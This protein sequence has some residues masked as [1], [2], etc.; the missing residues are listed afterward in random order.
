MPWLIYTATLNGVSITDSI[1]MTAISKDTLWSAIIPR[2]EAGSDIRY[3]IT[4]YDLVGSNATNTSGYSI[5]QPPKGGGT[6]EIIIGTG[7]STSYYSPYCADYNRSWTRA[8]YYDWEFNP[9]RTGALIASIAYDNNESR[10]STVDR[11]SMYVKATK[12]SVFTNRVYIDPVADGATLAWGEATYTT[13]Q[14]WNTFT[15]YTPF[16]LPPGYNLM[17]YWYDD[18]GSYDD[19]GMCT[20]NYT[21]QS[22]NNHIQ[23][24]DDEKLLPLIDARISIN[25]TRPNIKANM[26]QTDFPNNSVA[27]SSIKSPVQ[28]Q[29]VGGITTPVSV[30][31]HNKGD[32]NL[33]SATINWSVNNV[34]QTSVPWTGNLLWDFETQVTIGNYTP[35]TDMTDT[36]LIW[37]SSPNNKLDSVSSDD[38]LN[39]ITFGCVGAMAGTYTIGDGGMF[40]NINAFFTVLKD[41]IPSGDITLSLKT[42]TY[43]ENWDL[44]N[45]S[46]LMGNYTL[47]ITSF[48]ANADS[49]ILK[50]SSNVGIVL[51]N[52]NNLILKDITVDATAGT[53]AIQ[54]T[55]HCHNVMIRDCKLLAN[56][57]SYSTTTAPIYRRRYGPELVMD[58]VFIINNLLDGG[59]YGLYFRGQNDQ[60]DHIVFD[61]NTV[62]NQYYGIY[63]YGVDFISCSYNTI[64]C[65]TTN[66]SWYGIYLSYSHGN[67]IDNRI[68][69]HNSVAASSYGI[70]LDSYSSYDTQDTGLIANNEI[71]FH[72]TGSG[73]GIYVNYSRAKILYNSIYTISGSGISMPNAAYFCMIKNNNIIMESTDAFPIYLRTFGMDINIDYNNMYAPTYVGYAGGNKTTIQE[74]QQTVTTDHHSVSLYPGFIDTTINLELSN[75][76]GVRC[77]VLPDITRDIKGSFRVGS[78]SSMGCY[79]GVNYTLNAILETISGWRDGSVLGQTDTVKIQVTNTEKD[80]ITALIL[81]WAINGVQQTGITW[82]G[83]LPT[84]QN[85]I[86]PIGTIT[87][88]AGYYEI[89]AWISSVNGTQDEFSNDDT[90]SVIA[91]VCNTPLNGIYNIGATGDFPDIWEA[92]KILKLC[93]MDGDVVFAFQPGTYYTGN[94]DLT[95]NYKLFGNYQFTLTST[96][97]NA[98]DVVLKT[99][100]A[101]G[102][103]LSYSNNIVIKDL[104]IDA[105]TH[106][107]VEFIMPCTNIVIRDCRLLI[108]TTSTTSGVA[109]NRSVHPETQVE[110]I[111]S[112]FIINNFMDGGFY[113]I[114]LYGGYGLGRGQYGTNIV[115]D[116]NIISNSAFAGIWLQW[117]EFK[118]CSY[119][120]ILSRTVNIFS[121]WRGMYIGAGDGPVLSN[122]IIQRNTSSS[123]YYGIELD[124]YSVFTTDTGLV[125]NNEIILYANPTSTSQMC[126][127]IKI[128]S[129]LY[130]FSHAKILHNSIYIKG[131]SASR[132]IEI[133]DI[134]SSYLYLLTVMVKNNNIVMESPDAFPI[135]LNS[136]TNLQ[137]FD[138]DY[139]NMYA[140]TYVGYAGGNKATMAA[141]QQTITTDHNSVRVLPNIAN[142]DIS[143][144]PLQEFGLLCDTIPIVNQDIR[145]I[146][147]TGIAIMG[148]YEVLPATGNAMLETITGLREGYVLGQNDTI[149]VKVMNTGATA[150]TSVNFGW[151]V[152]GVI[153]SNNLSI[154]VSLSRWQSDTVSLGQLTYTAGKVVVKVWINSLNGGTLPDA[155]A[156]DDTLSSSVFVCNGGYSGTYIVGAT[157]DF[158]NMEE[159]C[160]AFNMCGVNG[161]IILAFQPGTYTDNIDLT[162]SA[163]IFGNYSL[164]LTSIT[165]IV[166]DVI[167]AP[168]AGVAINCNNTNNLTIKNITI[169]AT[170]GN[171]GI[172]FTGAASNITVDNCHILANPTATTTAYAAI[173]KS[174]SALNGFTVTNCTIDGGYYGIYLY[175]TSANSYQNIVIDNNIITNQYY[176]GMYLYYVNS[177]S[178]SYNHIIPRSTNAGTTWQ[179]LYG[180]YLRNGGNIVGNHISANTSAITSNLT[181]MYLYY[182][183]TAL[184]ANNEIYL[185]GNATTTDGIYVYYPRQVRVINNT[186]YT[187]KAGTSGTNRAHYNYIANGYSSEI[188]NNIFV[189]SGGAA[190]TTYAF[191]FYGS[192]A[193]FTNYKANYGV[194][195][196]DYYSTGTN[197]GYVAGA[198]RANLTVW[199][200]AI[201][202]LDAHSVNIFPDFANP[203][204]NLSLATYSDTLL[205]P[206]WQNVVT[207][208]RNL[209]RPDTTAMGAYI[210]FTEGKDLMLKG[211]SAWNNEVVNNQTIPVNVTLF[212][213]GT[214]PITTAT[215]GWSINNMPQTSVLWTAT[216]ALDLS[217]ERIVHLGSF[218][219]TNTSVHN[220]VVWIKDVNGQLDT[221]NWNDTI[222]ASASLKPLAEFVA[223]FLPDTIM[224]H[225]FNVNVLIRQGTGATIN[226]PKMTIISTVQGIG[227]SYD[228]VQLY[229]NGDI[230][231][232]TVPPQYLDAKVVYSVNISDSVGNTVTLT[233]SIYTRSLLSILGDTVLTGLSLSEPINQTGILCTPDFSSVSVMLENKGNMDYNFM[234]DSIAFELEITNPLQMKYTAHVPFLGKVSAGTSREVELINS[235]PIMYAGQY[236]IKVWI[237]RLVD[238]T[239]SEDTLHYTYTSSRYDLPIDDD[240]SNGIS[241]AFIPEGVNTSHTWKVINQG[242]GIDMAVQPV[243]G[244]SILSFTGSPGSMATLSTRQLDLSRTIQPSLSFWYFHDT[245]PCEDYTD[246]LITI[247]GG[248][249]YTTLLSV[250]KYDA[251]YGWKQ[252]SVDLPS[253]AINQCV[254]L[255][256]EAMEKSRSGNVTQY[257]DRILIIARQDIAISE[258]ITLELTACDLENR[259]VQVVLSNLTDPVLDFATTP[260]TITLE[261]NETGQTFSHSRTSGSLGSFASDTIPVATGVDFSPGTYTFKAYFSSVLDVDRMN[262]TL[263]ASIVINPALS[264]SVQPE[265][266]PANCLTGEL[267]VYPTITLYNMGNMDLSNIDMILQVDT[268]DNNTSVYTLLKE[269]YT[270]TILA[271]DTA[272]YMFNSTYTVPWN[273][274][275]NVRATAYLSCDST[276]VNSTIMITECVDTKDL[277][278]ISIDNSFEEK[279]TVGNNIQVTATLNN[280]CDYDDFPVVRI[281]VVVENSL[282][283]Q[284]ESFT[285]TQTV[286]LLATVSHTFVAS[287][288]VPD[289]S[290]YYLT[291]FVDSYDNYP[292]N[293]T[294]TI[295]KRE[296][297]KR[298]EEPEPPSVKGIDGSNAFTLGQNIP[299]PANNRTHIDYSIPEA[300][301]VVFHVH[302]VSGQLLYSKTIEAASGKQSL[303]LNTSTFAAGIYFYSIEYKGQRLVKRMMIS[304]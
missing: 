124:V 32:S 76:T 256:F 222:Y 125:A 58:N 182:I 163:T 65:R 51:E 64:L 198:N 241:M 61:S 128:I 283:E 224:S 239:T 286:G 167:F 38:T 284:T 213:M 273:A 252:Y 193:D 132:G 276:L 261:I 114:R 267:V 197:I 5:R 85:L 23:A 200:T 184:V 101:V 35:R 6:G 248:I 264:V 115:I 52:S 72:S 126:S 219:I 185:N 48:A 22:V 258:I 142:P 168:L 45:S 281:T 217:E 234:R 11:L 250:N 86:L 25:N 210:Q 202:P 103:T 88:T 154:P 95:D 255:V 98:S 63:A 59:Y 302:S 230:W 40:P 112:I 47:T 108:D 7:T 129:P 90:L 179:A 171:Y 215:L 118:S 84:E 36:I 243:F 290:V 251:V 94:I 203:T 4:G 220:I 292:D 42:G 296:T 67:V 113:G 254:R 119:N 205:C 253:F 28:G 298:P 157:G 106:I 39:I 279:D 216:P 66:I 137:N 172:Q 21:Q 209:K 33:T 74:W 280:R 297:V 238:N 301:E 228:T 245:I 77:A 68:I 156:G 9:Q 169:D 140:P 105:T 55:N 289:D 16:Y 269:T 174:G 57:T 54:F 99:T 100:D 18:D 109:I 240:F 123:P 223:P 153:Q 69:R 211:F 145:G 41:C 83:S 173:Y 130:Q 143:L 232:A 259:D 15:F 138:M 288:T 89:K 70:Y 181:G 247:D 107:A 159:A 97:H 8:I 3:S 93:R 178:I 29:T 186:I 188:K 176:Y 177:S 260:T 263:V 1:L 274:R 164:M 14:G 162:N 82:T 20:W 191:Y 265:S 304:D 122:H 218:P 195:Y 244:D 272:T 287:Y 189:A 294:A 24:Y 166:S 201:S 71:M 165:G 160:N 303:E 147:R 26:Q 295:I 196:N 151:S 148:C 75:Y 10:S 214:V 180:Y 246:I 50:P 116:S 146:T 192:S 242:T 229:P 149:K 187:I 300:G 133:S 175:G 91:Y 170:K 212:N 31:I 46:N 44:S 34:L 235:L 226:T 43:T 19:N 37:V 266:N 2:F 194:D 257:I 120:T 221:V 131:T 62:S 141:W 237:K 27:L 282:R 208:I 96:T 227:I 150:L 92:L 80:T 158:L 231:Q 293:D 204:N 275:Y 49:V 144:E 262:D 249:T 81:N 13:S 78:F 155:F 139:N 291:V 127:G 56:P 12:D 79:R 136:L 17:V 225:S 121:G 199:K 233:D 268:G 134:P 190:G 161:N 30:T 102:V 53:Y 285:E 299:N 110:P 277:R 236:D 271:G 207:D 152:N 111:D 117:A 73:V 87:Y 60:P 206:K 104:T 183:D 270:D 278:I 135:Y